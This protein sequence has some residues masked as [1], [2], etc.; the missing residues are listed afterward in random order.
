MAMRRRKEKVREGRM[1]STSPIVVF[2]RSPIPL[3]NV[4]DMK[5]KIIELRGRR[6]EYTI[7]LKE[8]FRKEG[9][10][11]RDGDGRVIEW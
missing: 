1:I 11:E 10:V 8:L 7:P 9:K 6:T 3:D 4:L 5:V 2:T